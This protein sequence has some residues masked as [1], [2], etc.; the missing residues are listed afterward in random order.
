MMTFR[1][2]NQNFPVNEVLDEIDTTTHVEKPDG[3]GYIFDDFEKEINL[4]LDSKDDIEVNSL[5]EKN[6]KINMENGIKEYFLRY[7]MMKSKNDEDYNLSLS[8]RNKA[9]KT[10]SLNVQNKKGSKPIQLSQAKE[11]EKKLDYEDK[12]SL[13]KISKNFST[14]EINDIK[15]AIDR[16]PSYEDTRKILDM[17]KKRLKSEEYERLI[18]IVDKFQQ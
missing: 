17:L 4:P 14:S 7:S 9:Y 8:N 15:R 16:G 3:T 6:K 11:Y 12:I 10:L 18:K 2:E 5:K 13:I 1:I